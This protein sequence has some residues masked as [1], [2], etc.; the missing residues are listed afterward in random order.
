[1]AVSPSSYPYVVGMLMSNS[2]WEMVFFAAVKAGFVAKEKLAPA[3]AAAAGDAEK[4]L[5]A[6]FEDNMAT[7][8]VSAK[9]PVLQAG[10]IIVSNLGG[11][12]HH[13][14]A[15]A[16]QSETIEDLEVSYV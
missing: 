13:V 14:F 12:F 15:V 2:C 8:K 3:Y 16:G 4:V 7:Y 11:P 5:F 1:M 9:P 6:I 10:G